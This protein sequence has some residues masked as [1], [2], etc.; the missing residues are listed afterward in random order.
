[1]AVRI[2]NRVAHVIFDAKSD[3]A[4]VRAGTEQHRKRLLFAVVTVTIA[5]A[6]RNFEAIVVAL[7]DDIHNTCN[8]VR[9][10]DR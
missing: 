9:T 6:A 5:E 10:V 7:Q 2:K 4:L 1:M 8:R 3:A